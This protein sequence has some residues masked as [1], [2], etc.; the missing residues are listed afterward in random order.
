[1][2]MRSSFLFWSAKG[3]CVSFSRNSWN[4]DPWMVMGS[5]P[6]D[7]RV[8]ARGCRPSQ[9]LGATRDADLGFIPTACRPRRLCA[10]PIGGQ[11]RMSFLERAKAA[12]ND[13]AAKADVAMTQA[14]ISTPGAPPGGGDRALRDLGVLAY[15]EATGRGVN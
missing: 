14:G 13:L 8:R 3:S 15:L 6:L 2:S 11:K 7:R 4:S 12:A 5:A 1:M 10:H 9:T